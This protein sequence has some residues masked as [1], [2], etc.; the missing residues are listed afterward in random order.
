VA[1]WAL[2]TQVLYCTVQHCIVLL[3]P[4]QASHPQDLCCCLTSLARLRLRP[5]SSK[6][7]ALLDRAMD[8]LSKFT[9][10]QLT[11]GRAVTVALGEGGVLG[12]GVFMV[13]GGV[14]GG[15]VKC[16]GGEGFVVEG[17]HLFQHEWSAQAHF[18]RQERTC[19]SSMGS[20]Q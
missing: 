17:G 19:S 16:G 9:P 10:R 8:S 6:V 3:S 7:V 18:H 13:L 20:C 2:P 1:S 5:D 4:T 12:G 14:R 15:K 11:G